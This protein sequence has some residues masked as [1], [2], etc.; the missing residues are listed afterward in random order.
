MPKPTKRPAEKFEQFVTRCMGDE[1]MNSDF[2]D[3]KQRR[4]VC[5]T[6]W[7]K[8]DK[9]ASRMAA[10]FAGAEFKA[11]ETA[12]FNDKGQLVQRFRKD[13]I[14]VGVYRHPYHEWSMDVT[15][16]RMDKWVA[17]FSVMRANGIDIEVVVDHSM[18]AE[19]VRG[20]LVDMFREGDTLYG[21]HELIGEDSIKLAQTVKNVSVLIEKE[22]VDGKGVSYGEAITHSSIVQQ[23]V[24]PG[25]EGFVPIAASR[26]VNSPTSIF[27]LSV[28]GTNNKQ[29]PQEKTMT[30]EMLKQIREILGAGEDFTE[31]NM[32]TRLAERITADT[33]EKL[34][35]SKDMAELKGQVE[36]LKSKDKTASKVDPD[37]LDDRAENAEEK[38][39]GLVEKAKITP[40]VAASL[41][42]ILVGEPTKRNAYMLSR[43]V[44]GTDKSVTYKIL[45]ALAE[46]DS[47]ELGEKTKSQSL[48]MSRSVPNADLKPDEKE[49]DRTSE[50]AMAASGHNAP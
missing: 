32:L 30:A 15:P 25:Q 42:E 13:M 28:E 3:D 48:S 39:D 11:A 49:V 41:K 38:I 19:A 29:N 50:I 21:I 17:T 9:G 47:V 22:Y 12:K 4:A 46:N 8:P 5:Q 34:K 24:V 43:K 45:G 44:S 2:P 31:E 14:S 26:G 10:A 18:D 36:S 23:P 20:Y 16:E 35:L 33:D 37:I 1:T 40:K 6:Q 7:A 27:V